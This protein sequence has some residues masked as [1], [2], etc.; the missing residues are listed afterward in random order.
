MSALIIA[1]EEQQHVFGPRG[2]TLLVAHEIGNDDAGRMIAGFARYIGGMIGDVVERERR[3]PSLLD[4]LNACDGEFRPPSAVRPAPAS[5][6]RAGRDMD[7]C[8]PLR[9]QGCA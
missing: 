5:A 1:V 4:K 2:L 6:T 7:P 3:V 9:R 8:R